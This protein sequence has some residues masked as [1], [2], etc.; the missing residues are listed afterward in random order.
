L[1]ILWKGRRKRRRN[2]MIKLVVF[3]FDGTLADTKSVV[4]SAI[5]N[6]LSKY[7]YKIPKNLM[8]TMRVGDRSIKGT[9]EPMVKKK[10][11]DS[12]VKRHN[13]RT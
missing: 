1:I 10:D 5:K 11:L 6:T 7:K 3:D 9:F 4:F 2:K 8:E 12:M 13:R